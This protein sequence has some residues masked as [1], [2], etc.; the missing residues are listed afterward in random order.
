VEE[1][2]FRGK[3]VDTGEW[4]YGYLIH[5]S[6]CSTTIPY[7]GYLSCEQAN[8]EDGDVVPVIP[9]TVGQYTMLKDRNDKRV[10]EQDICKFREWDNGPMCWVGHIF[11]ENCQ[12][13][14]SGGP[15]KECDS[16]F[17]ITLSRIPLRTSK[18]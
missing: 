3:R 7:I 11:Y 10:F 6:I 18:L 14:I 8:T 5:D 1:I 9:E 17:Y 12:Y 4:V 13:V 2:L 16:D 15:N